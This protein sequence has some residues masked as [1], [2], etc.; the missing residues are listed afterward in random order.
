MSEE[1]NLDK[2]GEFA[3]LWRARAE[4]AEARV[5]ELEAAWPNE[6]Q[7]REAL[8]AAEAKVAALTAKLAQMQ[9]VVE[10]A[11]PAEKYISNLHIVGGEGDCSGGP[12]CEGCSVWL[13]LFNAFKALSRLTAAPEGKPCVKCRDTGLVGYGN[14]ATNCSSCCPPSP[15]KKWEVTPAGN[16]RFCGGFIPNCPKCCQSTPEKKP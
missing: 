7:A 1:I 2:V 13:R 10:A 12:N 9:E 14:T 6:I 11:K 15:G 4:A 5:R 3:L 16:C 8:G